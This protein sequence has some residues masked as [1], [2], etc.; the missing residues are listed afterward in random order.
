[1]DARGGLAS[2][3]LLW[4]APEVPPVEIA[5]TVV[6]VVAV[7]GV[8][9]AFVAWGNAQR[10]LRLLAKYGDEK[11]VEMIMTRQIWEG[12]TRDQLIDS[13]GKPVEIDEKVLKTKVTHVYKYNRSSK[14]SFRERV[15]LDD[16]VVVGWDQ[17]GQR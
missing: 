10:R 9:I 15:K 17:K 14:T 11:A 7:I 8:I 6:A 4:S 3:D 13:W 12:M 1:M 5:L 16:G 2:P